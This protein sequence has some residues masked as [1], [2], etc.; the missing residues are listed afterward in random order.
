M[1]DHVTRL[2]NLWRA[3][4]D[5]G[6]RIDDAQF[7]TI[8]ISLLGEEW[9]TVVPVLHM[10]KTSAEVISFVTMHAER[11]NRTGVPSMAAPAPQALAANTNW[12]ARRAARKNLVCTNAQCGAPSKKGN[13]IADCFWPGGGKAGQWPAWWKGK[14]GPTAAAN[15]VESF[16]FSQRAGG[17]RFLVYVTSDTESV[18]CDN[19][20]GE[21]VLIRTELLRNP[22]F[23]L[24]AWYTHLRLA[25]QG[26]PDAV[27][28]FLTDTPQPREYRVVA[29]SASTDH[30][31]WKREDF[32]EYYPVEREG[33]AAEGSKFRILATGV[34]RKTI[35]YLGQKK[36]ITLN[37]IHTPDITVNLISVSKLD[38]GGFSVEFGRGKAVF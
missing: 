11:L 26:I 9:D 3:A 28:A 24:A 14:R 27:L 19:H 37:A 22:V 25:A 32:V 5:M 29:D 2:R 1:S 13:A 4:N 6:A 18:I 16:A 23:D 20:T 7:R 30:C 38:A 33:K 36:E 12:D 21:D 10:F 34:V 35:T 17:R 8:F 15:A 31:F